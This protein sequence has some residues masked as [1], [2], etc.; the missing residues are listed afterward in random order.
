MAL[1]NLN[2]IKTQEAV[3]RVEEIKRV[4]LS[5][6]E[7]ELLIRLVAGSKTADELQK[8]MHANYAQLLLGIKHLLLQKKIERKRGYPTRYQLSESALMLAK[9]LRTQ[10]DMS[11]LLT[12]PCMVPDSVSF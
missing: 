3:P 4:A 10:L 12:D 7:K 1:V 2:E 5:S 8:A 11:D 6:L 9:K